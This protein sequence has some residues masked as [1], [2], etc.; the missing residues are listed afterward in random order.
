MEPLEFSLVST[1]ELRIRPPAYACFERLTGIIVFTG[2]FK[3]IGPT[4]VILIRPTF[5]PT[6]VIILIRP[7]FKPTGVFKL[8]FIS[9]LI[10]RLRPPTIALIGVY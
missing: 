9:I 3:L 4:G 6:G 1:Q 5:R 8:V 10:F 7:T 2:I